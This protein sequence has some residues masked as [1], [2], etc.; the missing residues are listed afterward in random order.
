MLVNHD[1]MFHRAP[2]ILSGQLFLFGGVCHQHQ[3]SI[4]DCFW[5]LPTYD[6]MWV[7]KYA[8][9]WHHAM[10]IFVDWHL[11]YHTLRV[12]FDMVRCHTTMQHH[13][14]TTIASIF[15][16]T[17]SSFQSI[18]RSV[19]SNAS[20]VGP[21]LLSLVLVVL[22]YA[23]AAEVSDVGRISTVSART[24]VDRRSFLSLG[25]CMMKKVCS[26]HVLVLFAGLK[27][28]QLSVGMFTH[29]FLWIFWCLD[30]YYGWYTMS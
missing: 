12:M 10:Y 17:R 20:V 9:R 11:I 22:G 5:L 24:L 8:S 28:A 23:L 21:T 14:S 27:I 6:S 16:H 13:P 3:F 19:S 1:V 18:A 2:V 7:A 26:S 4:H 30:S 25:I 15:R 29:G